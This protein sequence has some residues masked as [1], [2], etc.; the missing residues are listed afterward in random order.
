MESASVVSSDRKLD[1]FKII[2]VIVQQALFAVTVC[3]CLYNLTT[4]DKDKEIWIGIF[5]MVL[6]AISANIKNIKTKRNGR[7]VFTSPFINQYPLGVLSRDSGDYVD[8]H[9]KVDIPR[10]IP[11]KQVTAAQGQRVIPSSNDIKHSSV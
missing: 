2:R 6:G 3:V 9:G 4:K 1:S 10:H 5:G 11:P 7:E 8:S